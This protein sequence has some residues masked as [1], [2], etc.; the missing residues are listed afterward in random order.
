MYILASTLPPKIPV[1]VPRAVRRARRIQ[2]QRD[3]QV[4]TLINDI[5]KIA[6]EEID[7]LRDLANEML[8]DNEQNPIVIENDDE[9]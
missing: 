4:K 5:S 1:K 6:T 3:H 7:R 8:D 2:K 9:N